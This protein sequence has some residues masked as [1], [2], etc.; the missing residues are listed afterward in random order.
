MSWR[1]PASAWPRHSASAPPLRR[2]P[3]LAGS[4]RLLA[5]GLGGG[6]RAGAFLDL[7]EQRAD[8]DGLAVLGGDLAEHA[9][10]GRR[11]LDRHLVGLELDQR[12]VDGDRIARL[13]EPVADGRLG[14]RFAERG[15]ADFSHGST[16]C[17]DRSSPPPAY[18]MPALRAASGMTHEFQPSASSR[19]AL[20]CAR[21]FDI[22]P[23]AV[24]AEAGRP[25]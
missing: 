24:A 9:G 18:W 11:H 16:S 20:S 13:L 5:A 3:A 19:N 1:E 14:H 25:A 7:A 21:C 10:R 2:L 4:A 8:R 12:L 17:H 22:T 6:R 15:D 23:T